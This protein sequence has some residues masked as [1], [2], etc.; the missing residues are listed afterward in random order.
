MA[1]KGL[2][3][4]SEEIEKIAASGQI[5]AS[6]LMRTAALVR[7]GVT[8]AELNSF[9]EE[10]IRK[11]GGRPSF[12]NYGNPKNPFPAGLCTSVNDVI[13][14]GI[15]S[16][17]VVLKEGDI[18]G[19]DLGVEFKGYY[20]DSARTVAVGRISK[21]AERLMT[22]TQRA[23][24]AAIFEAV[25]GNRTGD[26]GHAIQR[27][28]EKEGFTV[29]RELIGHGVGYAVHEEPEVPCFGRVSEGVELKEGMVLAIEP[30]VCEGNYRV[31]SEPGGW[32]VRTA[33]HS[34]SAHFEHTVAVTAQGP[35]ILT[36]PPDV[37]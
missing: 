11:M 2:I 18:V 13:V 21:T 25:I 32:E 36:L 5:L 24:E 37:L 29:V 3:K 20:S 34:L 7:P 9:A 30:M 8:T 16:K 35:R 17:T 22:V 33:D 1:K 26:I 12:K 14:H 28:A 4:T 15:P 6:V 23:L 19:L 10:E 27:T 31:A